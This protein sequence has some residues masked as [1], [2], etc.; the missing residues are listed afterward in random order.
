MKEEHDGPNAFKVHRGYA[1]GNPYTHIK[2]KKTKAQVIVS[3]REEAIDR[4]KRYFEESLKLPHAIFLVAEIDEILAGYCGLY[5][6]FNE[7]LYKHPYQVD[8]SNVLYIYLLIV[9]PTKY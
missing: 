4:Y 9:D 1:L 8:K 2:D 3:T 6:V 5:K 7:F